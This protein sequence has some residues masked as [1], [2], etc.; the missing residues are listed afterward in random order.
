MTE[1][2][3]LE[4]YLHGH[5]PDFNCINKIK[6]NS[7]EEYFFVIGTFKDYFPDIEKYETHFGMEEY[8][9]ETNP[10]EFL[11]GETKPE[12]ATFKPKQYPCIYVFCPLEMDDARIGYSV[13]GWPDDFIYF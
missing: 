10:K 3:T 1:D 11:N 4:D 2:V 7:D 12:T 6:L 5:E 8:N 13:G 9:E